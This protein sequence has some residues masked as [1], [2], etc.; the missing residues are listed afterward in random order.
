VLAVKEILKDRLLGKREAFIIDQEGSGLPDDIVRRNVIGTVF[1]A[2][3]AEEALGE[4]LAEPLV[5]IPVSFADVFD[6]TDFAPGHQGL[7]Q[8]LYVDRTLGHAS[9]ALHALVGLLQY[10]VHGFHKKK[11]K[12]KV[13]DS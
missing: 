10:F 11:V 9:A 2:G 6:Q 13:M 12:L 8:R 7:F 5:E 1:R 4:D 3:A